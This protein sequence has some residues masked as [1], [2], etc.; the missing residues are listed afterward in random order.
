MGF[1]PNQAH[2]FGHPGP[3]YAQQPMHPPGHAYHMVKMPGG[4]GYYENGG[5]PQPPHHEHGQQAAAQNCNVHNINI[6]R[7]V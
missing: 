3:M 7:V 4:Y 2:N 5:V 6:H 1:G